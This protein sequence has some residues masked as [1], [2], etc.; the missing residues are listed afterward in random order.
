[1][2]ADAIQRAGSAMPSDFINYILVYEANADGMPG[3]LSD[4]DD[5]PADCSGITNCVR[6]VW[7]DSADAFRYG[8]GAWNSRLISAC[9]PGSGSHPLH[10]VGVYMN[11]THPMMVGLFGSTLT[12]QDRA[13]LD[14]EPLPT[15]SCAANQHQ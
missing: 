14:F 3:S 15:Q 5:M 11:A 10:R 9:F 12:L 4:D 1:M 7:R 13:V 2:A 8:G 6:F